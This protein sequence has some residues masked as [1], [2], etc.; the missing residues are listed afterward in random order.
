MMRSKLQ[1]TALKEQILVILGNSPP[2]TR[3]HLSRL[4][5]MQFC[6][7]NECL[8]ELVDDGKVQDIIVHKSIYYT[9]KK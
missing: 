6:Q 1:K 4:T 9:I 2:V 5:M 7:V 3:S 8:G